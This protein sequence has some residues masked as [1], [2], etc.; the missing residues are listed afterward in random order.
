MNALN[1][2][3]VMDTADSSRVVQPSDTHLMQSR[4]G[5]LV[6][7][8]TDRSLEVVCRLVADLTSVDALLL[9]GD[10]AGDESEEA[11]HRLQATLAPLDVPSVWLPGNHDALWSPEHQLSEH[12]K[13]HI[14]FSHW[15]IL[16]LNTQRRGMVAG[17]LSD[18]ELQALEEAIQQ[19]QQAQ[20]AQPPMPVA[21]HHPL[22]PVGWE[23]LD[24]IGA[25][26]GAEALR[27]LAPLTDRALVI[28]GHVYQD[29]TQ[30][31]QGVQCLTTPSTCLQFAPHSA[32]FKVDSLAPGCRLI[33]LHK[34]GAWDTIVCRVTDGTFEVDMDSS[35]CA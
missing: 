4:G 6:E 15:A 11:Y 26:N 24:E 14:R 33:N 27:R 31:C 1:G 20:Q 23:W 12:C 5:K 3:A 10:L 13:R 21:T 29:S 34:N 30:A 25:E 22:M 32:V 9:T 18:D 19:A 28:S 16:M 2:L 35:G 7:V 8:D 17:H